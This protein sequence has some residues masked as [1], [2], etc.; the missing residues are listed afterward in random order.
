MRPIPTS[1]HLGPVEIHT[2][3]IGLAIAFWVGYRYFEHRLAKR[4][5]PTDWLAGFFLW[6]IVSAI[7]GAR[8]M[9][10][11]SDL[12]YYSSHPG[13]I[14]AIWQGGLSSFGG[15]L[16]AVPVA[17]IITKKRCPDLGVLEGLDIV[18]PALLV[19]WAV[20]RLLGP[21]LMV[22]GGGHPTNQ[23]FGMY[24]D[25]Q[26]GKRIPVPLIQAAEDLTVYAILMLT[27][28]RLGRWKNGA[29]RVGYP[30]GIITGIGMI[31]WGIERTVD[32]RLWLGEV[33]A[34][35]SQLVQ[36]A[37]VLLVIGGIII[38]I[39]SRTKWK[40]WLST[41][42]MPNLESGSAEVVSEP[43]TTSSPQPPPQA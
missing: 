6:V 27:E 42:E 19:A 7:L 17:I 28:R 41:R 26:V 4:G 33:G 16:A 10:V 13:Q 21:Q 43:S 22:G 37:G 9:H 38:L 18:M 23:W 30:A 2:Y 36:V 12:G 25:G 14:F 24:Y 34:L 40:A 11:L 8:A 15:L 32:E 31:L 3:G 5:Y 35:G 39:R 20:G 1:F 29:A